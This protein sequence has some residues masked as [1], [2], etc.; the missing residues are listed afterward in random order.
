MNIY[1]VIVCALLFFFG[2]HDTGLCVLPSWNIG[3]TKETGSQGAD[4]RRL[5]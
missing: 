5:I 1:I 3:G 2:G 4:G